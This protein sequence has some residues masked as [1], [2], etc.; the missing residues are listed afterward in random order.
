M[1]KELENLIESTFTAKKPAAPSLDLISLVESILDE[2]YSQV[3][4]VEQEEGPDKAKVEKAREF[5]L[6]LPK[7]SPNESWG[8]PNSVER[9]TVNKIFGVIGG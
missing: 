8:D 6:T 5:L 4:M 9:E 3:I 7:F 2:V 1:M